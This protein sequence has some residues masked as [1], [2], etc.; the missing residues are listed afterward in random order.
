MENLK[1]FR[2]RL[3]IISLL[4]EASRFFTLM[5]SL[6]DCVTKRLSEEKN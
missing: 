1:Q 2:L 3:V 4:T 6:T 5:L